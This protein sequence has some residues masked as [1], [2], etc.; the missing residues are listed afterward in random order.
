[1]SS[2]F[3]QGQLFDRPTSFLVD[4]GSPVSLVQNKVCILSKPPG[5]VLRPW[6][7]NK[8]A[9]VNGTALHS[10]GSSDVTITIKG[11]IFVITMVIID[12]L[13]VDAILGLDFLEANHCNLAV[14]E[15]LLH[16]P[17]Y[18]LSVPVDGN[19]DVPTSLSAVATETR[20]VPPYSELEIMAVIPTPCMGKPYIVETNQT[21]NTFVAARALVNPTTGA[22][23]V[24][25]L[26]PCSE[27][28][29]IYK[30]TKIATLEEV[31][32]P[33]SPIS[34]VTVTNE[35]RDTNSQTDLNAALWNIV[36]SS[37]TELDSNQQ[38][39]L[40]RLLLEFHDVFATGQHD[41]GH[42][43]IIKHQN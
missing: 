25:L 20:V 28:T 9:G 33:D 32:E 29:T 14:R 26:N 43:S 13:A 2:F 16:I 39:D 41:L 4:T 15:R 8:L 21:K 18:E 6:G 34:A 38:Q 27:A 42:T 23:P 19:C 37:D 31:V 36:S 17:S 35:S 40:Y 22:I 24:R 12:D 30:G 5:N 1:M 7:G 10:Q 3:I 11:K